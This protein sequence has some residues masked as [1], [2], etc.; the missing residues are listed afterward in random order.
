MFCAHGL[1]YSYCFS[2]HSYSAGRFGGGS[3]GWPDASEWDYR[4][5]MNMPVCAW[6]YTDATH[7]IR[8]S[9]AF[10]AVGTRTVRCLS[11]PRG[12]F[13]G[14]V[15]PSMDLVGRSPPPARANF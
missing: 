11:E 7:A 12:V 10:V 13:R 5:R 3:S 15:R 1:I 14:F 2:R 9:R 6:E 8:Q 4:Q